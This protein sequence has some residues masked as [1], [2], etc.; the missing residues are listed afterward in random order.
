METTLKRFRKKYCQKSSYNSYINDDR[1]HA[2][3]VNEDN[4]NNNKDLHVTSHHVKRYILTP[5]K[6]KNIQQE[7]LKEIHLTVGNSARKKLPATLI[8]GDSKVKE[9]KGWELLN[10]SNGAST[11]DMKSNIQATI[12]NNPEFIVLHCDNNYL[13]QST[14]AVEIGQKLLGISGIL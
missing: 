6:I 4:H 11:D 5:I 9:V 10:E 13:K 2:L 1:F 14:S 8:L 12:W 7:K 3:S